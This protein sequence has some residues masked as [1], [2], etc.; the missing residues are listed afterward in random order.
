MTRRTRAVLVAGLLALTAT[1]SAAL[2]AA[3]APSPD[4]DDAAL[5]LGPVDIEMTEPTT[6]G[7]CERWEWAEMERTLYTLLLMRGRPYFERTGIEGRANGASTEDPRCIRNWI[8]SYRSPYQADDVITFELFLDRTTPPK[9]SMT[10]PSTPLP[11]TDMNPFEALE[12]VRAAGYSSNVDSIRLAP[13]AVGEAQF[14]AALDRFTRIAVNPATGEIRNE[15]VPDLPRNAVTVTAGGYAP[16]KVST[17]AAVACPATHPY[18]LNADQGWGARGA[19]VA[20]GGAH[21]ATVKL[22]L[23]DYRAADG[24]VTGWKEAP[25][26]ISNKAEGDVAVYALCTSEKK[27][28]MRD[29]G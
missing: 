6:P 12:R 16:S 14:T 15:A 1:L 7:G 19:T 2:P 24:Y 29:A 20:G 8:V 26:G 18:L 23:Y 4:G 17:V 3:A 25:D 22:S 10:G 27:Q 21:R 5:E 9:F 11:A 28:A 13:N